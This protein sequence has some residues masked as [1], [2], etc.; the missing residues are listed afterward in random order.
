MKFDLVEA[1]LGS[2]MCSESEFVLPTEERLIALEM[3]SAI[4]SNRPRATVLPL[5]LSVSTYFWLELLLFY[6]SR[7]F[8]DLK[9]LV[10]TGFAFWPRAKIESLVVLPCSFATEYLL[11]MEL[12]TL[13][14]EQ[15]PRFVGVVCLSRRRNET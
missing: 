8:R 1:M 3:P 9:L 12:L 5:L 15:P 7:S 6:R 10:M 2:V 14:F 11:T 4:Y 13:R